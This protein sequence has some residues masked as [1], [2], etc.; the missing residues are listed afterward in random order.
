MD[1]Q[2]STTILY[3]FISMI[4]GLTALIGEDHLLL[5]LGIVFLALGA[6][7]SRPREHRDT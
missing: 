1:H 3:L 7:N 2:Q 5:P 4:L 6:Y